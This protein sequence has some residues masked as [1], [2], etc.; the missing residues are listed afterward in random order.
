[1]AIPSFEIIGRDPEREV[2]EALLDGPRPSVLVLDGEA[3]I[4]KTTLWNEGVRAAERGGWR[5]LS[6]SA[7]EQETT[8]A[9]AVAGDLL[10]DV[11]EEVADRLAP[12]QRRALDVAL[13]RVESDQ[14]PVSPSL[15]DCTNR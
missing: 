14:V 13:L 7:A 11:L 10:G 1:M 3:G 12:V 4:G 6:A 15:P 2:I 8:L 5:V 9:F